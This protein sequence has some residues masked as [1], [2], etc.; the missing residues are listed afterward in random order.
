MKEVYLLRHGEKDTRGFL[1]ERGKRAAEAMRSV[2]PGFVAVI[3]SGSDRTILTAKLLTGVEPQVDP[4]AAYATAPA[5]VSGVINN[6]AREQNISFWDAARQ[7]N[8]S[9]VLAGIEEQ[10]RAL[11]GLVDELLEGLGENQRALVVSHDLTITP[12]MGARG[13][14]SESIEPLGG[15]VVS[16]QDGVPVV[17]RY[18]TPAYNATS[19]AVLE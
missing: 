6:L 12:A 16:V 10:A 19:F 8:D 17:Q 3:S 14:A 18:E 11:N 15:Y 5:D 1:T 4:R 2:L 9:D 13:M 7:H